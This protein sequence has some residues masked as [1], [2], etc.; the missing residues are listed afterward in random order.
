MNKKYTYYLLQFNNID[1]TWLI[2]DMVSN[3]YYTLNNHEELNLFLQKLLI[4]LKKI[5]RTTLY[6]YIVDLNHIVNNKHII[7]KNLEKDVFIYKNIIYSI[8]IKS[9][10][11]ENK[12]LVFKDYYNFFTDEKH[13]TILEKSININTLINNIYNKFYVNVNKDKILSLASI[14]YRIFKNIDKNNY[15]KIKKLFEKEDDFIRKSYFGGRTEI[16]RFMEKDLYYYDVN[17]LYPFIMSKQ[18]MPI[19]FPKYCK[20][21]DLTNFFGF[22]KVL[23][24]APKDIKLPVL[25]TKSENNNVEM[26]TI[27]PLG[28]FYGTYFSEELK[29]AITQGYKIL[30]IFDGYTFDTDIIFD[31]FVTKLYALRLTEQDPVVKKIYKIIMNS[32]YGRFASIYENKYELFANN[33]VIKKTYNNVSVSSAI[34]SYARIFMHNYIVQ[35]N[36]DLIYWDT[37]GIFTKNELKSNLGKE[38]GNFKCVDHILKIVFIAPKF[39]MYQTN[40]DYVYVFRGITISHY[41][42]LNKG[43]ILM[44]FF[45]KEMQKI[46]TNRRFKDIKF[47]LTRKNGLI[48][49]FDF[50]FYNKR[51]LLIINNQIITKPW[52]IKYVII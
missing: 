23:I 34:T 2:V 52:F 46:S 49:T 51:E 45:K 38:L 6:C 42:L 19:G 14:S 37:D 25:P 29:Y 48:D 21:V 24:E 32:L 40:I 27:Y 12:K 26:G 15:L 47:G 16:F 7:L 17:S 50:R 1:N 9:L 20:N 36:V 44:E 22:V 8:K 41:N 11:L 31:N 10:L 4:H 35:N 43:Q 28:T 3:T 30:K 13:T 5:R 18:K 33:F 39:Y